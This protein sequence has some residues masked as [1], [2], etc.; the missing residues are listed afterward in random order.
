[1]VF[2]AVSFKKY[3]HS[4]CTLFASEQLD[5][6][7]FGEDSASIANVPDSPPAD[8]LGLKVCIILIS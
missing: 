3:H 6:A 5:K 2:E 7:E 1:M 8:E 4:K